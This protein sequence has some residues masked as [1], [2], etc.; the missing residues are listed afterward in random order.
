[1]S[2]KRRAIGSATWVALGLTSAIVTGAADAQ[3]AIKIGFVGG[4]SGPAAYDGISGLTAARVAAQEINEAGGLLGRKVEVVHADSRNI[5]AEA[6]SALRKLVVQDKIVAVDCCWASSATIAAL[7]SL[8][9]LKIPSTN[10]NAF[11]PDA[12][13]TKLTW[14][15]KCSHTARLEARFADYWVKKM[16]LKRVA[17][18]A[19]NDDWGRGTVNAFQERLKELGATVVAAELYN[20]GEKDFYT[21]LTKINALKPEG[22]SIIEFSAPAAAIVKQMAELGVTAKR[23]GSDG[24]ITDAFIKIAGPLTEGIPLVV[25]YS[26]TMDTARNRKFVVAYRAMRDGDYP[27][28]YAAGVYDSV[29]IQAEAIRRAGS[30]DPEKIREAL[31]KTDYTSIA[32]S[33]IRFDEN[34]QAIPKIF[35]A[36]VKNGKRVIVEEID[37]TGVQY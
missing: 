1:M 23:L 12:R 3:E 5:P 6:V 18:M 30:T 26:D 33:R 17:L 15:F 32:G 27:D 19:R 9:E 13:T 10:C 28:Q 2:W 7:P 22:V 21:S 25:R 11:F 14:H 16:G 35:V 36:A 4:L 8:D 37:T 24:P 20:P 29:Y 31:L 34:Q